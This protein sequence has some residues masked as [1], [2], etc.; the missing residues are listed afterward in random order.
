LRQTLVK[1]D[2]W[3][4][5]FDSRIV[6][7]PSDLR[8]PQLGLDAA[9]HRMLCDR[10][11]TIYHCAT[12]MNHLETYQM[13]KTA[14]VDANREL[15]AIATQR[16]PKL[17]NYVSTLGVFGHQPGVVRRVVNED[18]S[19]DHEQHYASRGY[20]A[21]KWVGEKLFLLAS[22]RGIPCNIFRLGLA[23]ADTQQGRYDELQRGYR[24]LKSC[25]LSGYGIENFAFEMPPTPVDYAARAMVHLARR[26]PGG[27]G[28]FH[29]S[30]ATQMAAGVFECCNELFGS[31]LALLP[32]Y[33]WIG[34]M[35]R[36]HAAGM[37]LPIVPLIEFA[38]GMSESAFSDYQ[39]G[40]HAWRVH[41]DCA[42]THRELDGS[43]IFAPALDEELLK[44]CIEGML[45]RDAELQDH[46]AHED[47]G[48][49][50]FPRHTPVSHRAQMGA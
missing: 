16:R 8:L 47:D 27:G 37:S 9:T 18:A 13:A 46:L 26:H 24:I 1:W 33:E 20:V 7:I 28:V 38:F 34:E 11:G 21:S 19:I 6:A 17:V 29:I 10:I 25:L 44:L 49:S 35:K 48:R 43:G 36:L 15:L 14:N 5:E 42:R 41:W 30:S 39:R 32:W 31:S 45:A 12:S 22:A 3:R 23:W 40:L 2:L 50:F 4:A